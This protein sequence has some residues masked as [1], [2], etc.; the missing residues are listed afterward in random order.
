MEIE[1]DLAD[2]VRAVHLR[3]DAAASRQ[4]TDFLCRKNYTRHSRDVAEKHNAGLG[5]EGVLKALNDFFRAGRRL[6]KHNCI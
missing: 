1:W 6:R 2:G 4:P 5:G 3:E